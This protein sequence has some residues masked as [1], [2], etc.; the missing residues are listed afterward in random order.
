MYISYPQRN[1][2][3]LKNLRKN[4]AKLTS[5][6]AIF[7]WDAEPQVWV[8]RAGASG[9]PFRLLTLFWL[10]I[11]LK[12][13]EFH[14]SFQDAQTCSVTWLG[15]LLVLFLLGFLMLKT[16]W[17]YDSEALVFQAFVTLASSSGNQKQCFY[18]IKKN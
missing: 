15:F 5:L 10:E 13:S 9:T 11:F 1:T 2:K 12:S 17:L 8:G 3:I 14:F 4:K 18:K 6:D 7:K 16:Y